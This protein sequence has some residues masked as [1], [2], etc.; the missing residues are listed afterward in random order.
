MKKIDAVLFDLDG[1]LI[2]TNEIIVA[3]YRHAYSRHLPNLTISDQEIID[4]IGPTLRM[5]FSKHTNDQ[6]LID[7]LIETYRTYYTEN[8]KKYHYLYPNVV[9]TL[10]E[11]KNHNLKLAIVTSKFKDAAWPS[12]SYYKLEQFFDAFIALDDVKNPKPD[13]EPVE[14][15]LKL[16]GNPQNAIMIGDNQGDIL[17]GKNANILTAG[18]A[19]SIKGATHLKKVNPD[20][21]FEDMR[22]I[23]NLI[24]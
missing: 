17:S 5:I 22:D 3:S 11:L 20:F 15:A 12:F 18:V 14:K 8:E 16:L 24:K 23:I 6:Y 2:N 4:D 10:Q 21:I 9:E 7:T 1:T 13:K 19:W